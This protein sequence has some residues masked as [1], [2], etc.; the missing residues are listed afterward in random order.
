MSY[1]HPRNEYNK[2]ILSWY[3]IHL[4]S[5]LEINIILNEYLKLSVKYY[6]HANIR[7]ACRRTS[8]AIMMSCSHTPQLIPWVYRNSAMNMLTASLTEWTLS[9]LFVGC[10]YEQCSKTVLFSGATL[11]L[12]VCSVTGCSPF[13]NY[14]RHLKIAARIDT[15]QFSCTTEFEDS[16]ISH[17]MVFSS[18]I[19]V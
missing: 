9:N 11:I 16:Q 17:K 12:S 18:L 3:N 4:M 14:E 5:N 13:P 1:A 7:R 8:S 10:H 19:P 2:N 6:L 15:G